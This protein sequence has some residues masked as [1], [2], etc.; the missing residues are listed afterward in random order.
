MM[1]QKARI[2]VSEAG[3]KAAAATISGAATIN[4]GVKIRMFHANRPFVYAI[5][6]DDSDIIFF[7]GKYNG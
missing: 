4:I 1:K 7:V 3:A 2:E 6:E 5:I